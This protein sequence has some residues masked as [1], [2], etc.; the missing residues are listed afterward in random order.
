MPLVDLETIPQ[1]ELPFMNDDHREEG[2]L[3]N[4]AA[5]ALEAFRAGQEGKDAVL[6]RLAELDRHTREHFGREEETMRGAG[7]P[8]A[9][10]HA[11]EHARVLAEMEG[12]VAV[13][14]DSGD[15]ARL[16]RYLTQTVPAWFVNH[17]LS[18]DQI[19][20]RFVAMRGG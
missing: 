8:P 17:I 9:P 16:G 12:E 6:A 5:E 18:M 19:T 7:F 10:V 1:V 20:A 11:A 3:L 15:A 14:R 13:F 4:R 2:H